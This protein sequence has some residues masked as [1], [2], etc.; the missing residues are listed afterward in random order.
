MLTLEAATLRDDRE[1]ED[2]E[3]GRETAGLATIG[4]VR[5]EDTA[6]V[7]GARAALLEARG[8]TFAVE[9]EEDGTY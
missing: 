3:D 5:L 8:S 7:E 1:L 9:T 4:A 2:I 6:I